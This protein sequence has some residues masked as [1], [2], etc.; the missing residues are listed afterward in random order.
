MTFDGVL[1]LALKL[2][3]ISLRSVIAER[4]SSYC[5]HNGRFLG[6]LPVTILQL[7]SV[8]TQHQKLMNFVTPILDK[9]AAASYRIFRTSRSDFGRQYLVLSVSAFVCLE[10]TLSA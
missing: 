3:L 6:C 2:L 10:K 4:N 5:S 8:V 9:N 7:T 1:A